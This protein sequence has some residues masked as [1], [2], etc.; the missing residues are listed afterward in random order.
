MQEMKATEVEKTYLILKVKKMMKWR[1]MN[2][3]KK[4]AM[5]KIQYV[6]KLNERSPR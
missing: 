4:K 5:S 6:K 3:N 2:K 1:Q